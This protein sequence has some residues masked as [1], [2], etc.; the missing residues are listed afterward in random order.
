MNTKLPIRNKNNFIY[1]EEKLQDCS[2]E[3]KNLV[4]IELKKQITP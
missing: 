4:F 2:M 3:F 1:I